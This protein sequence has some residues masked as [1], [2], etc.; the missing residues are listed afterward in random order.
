MHGKDYFWCTA[1]HGC[2]GTK[3]NGMYADHKTCNHNLWRSHMDACHKK[4]ICDENDGQSN[5]TPSKP[6]DGP[7]QKLALNG[8]LCNA[9]GTQTGLSAEAID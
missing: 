6:A 1:D 7:S 2:G 9:F 5:T 3:H 4:R 8:M